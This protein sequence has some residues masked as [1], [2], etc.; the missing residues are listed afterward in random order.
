MLYIW[1]R[2]SEMS[3]FKEKTSEINKKIGA[4]YI[5]MK[6]SDTP[7][8]SKLACG[9]FVYYALSPLDLIPDF[10]PVLG[11]LDDFII[12][13]FLM[14]LAV[15]LV[16][17]DIM[18]ECTAQADEIWLEGGHTKKRYALVVIAIWFILLVWIWNIATK[19]IM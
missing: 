2:G 3:G 15:K 4:M 16:P 10:I 11:A 8:Y 12:L 7:L 1:I 5:A 9:L 6:R 19:F 14:W 13:P 18:E 17:R